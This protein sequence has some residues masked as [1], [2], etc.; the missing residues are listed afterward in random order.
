MQKMKTISKKFAGI[1]RNGAGKPENSEN[2]ELESESLPLEE[3]GTR[4][5]TTR[6]TAADS[7]EQDFD[8]LGL[9]ETLLR[10]VKSEGYLQPTPI[11]A[12]SIP[13][14]L[15]GK[16]LLGCAQTGTG[17]TASFALPILHRLSQE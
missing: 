11:Q 9:H 1:F 5:S 13:H 7:S 3:T 4:L 2:P 14:L 16:D 17:K 10:A 15:M 6:A 8:S 12:Q